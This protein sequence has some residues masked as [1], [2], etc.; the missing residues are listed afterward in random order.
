MR[1]RPHCKDRRR[2]AGST[3]HG[4]FHMVYIH[5]HISSS[6]YISGR[7][8][9]VIIAEPILSVFLYAPYPHRPCL[10][11]P[12]V[13]IDHHLPS[14]CWSQRYL[15][16]VLGKKQQQKNPLTLIFGVLCTSWS[17]IVSLNVPLLFSHKLLIM[18]LCKLQC[19]QSNCMD[20]NN[21]R[22]WK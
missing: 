2:H 6:P 1:A 3:T 4:H 9:K 16:T 18:P 12:P 21:I 15:Q 22:M 7:L 17:I 8:V 5:G 19:E 14:C 10:F 20:T 11:T 13:T